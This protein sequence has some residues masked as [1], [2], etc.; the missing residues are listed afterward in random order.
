MSVISDRQLLLVLLASTVIA[1]DWRHPA[2]A[3]TSPAPGTPVLK[4]ADPTH[5]DTAIA[6]R[7]Q[8]DLETDRARVVV[9]QFV[10]W[11]NTGHQ[12]ADRMLFHVA[13]NHR[14]TERQCEI[15]ER[16]IESLRIEPRDSLDRHGR[17][18]HLVS[19]TRRGRKLRHWF[20]PEADTHLHVQLDRFV[21]TGESIEVQLDYWIDLPPL[22]GRVGQFRGVTN[23]LN[24]YPVLAVFGN[25]GWD[26]TPFVGWHQPW[27]NE[28]G[29]YEVTLK[30]PA[31]QRVATG[32]RVLSRIVDERGRQVLQ[33][34]GRSLRDFTIVCSN[35]FESY[36]SEV[37]GI[38]IRVLA[39]LEDQGN[40]RLAL[41][42]AVESIR[43]FSKW[44][45]PYPCREFELVETYFGW[46]GNESSGLVMIDQRIL[47]APRRAGLYV[48]H[49]VTHEI[50]H[51][52]WYSAVGTDG[53]REPFMDE[54][55]VA[56]LTRVA[57]EEKYG[58]DPGVL[59]VPGAGLCGLPNIPYQTLVGSG[60]DLY[61]DRG[62]NGQT[63]STLSEFGHV[64]NL[65]FHVY[66]RGAC[67]VGMIQHRL[68]REWFLAFLSRVYRSYRFRIIHIAD[69]QRELEKFTGQ[70]WQPFFD[71][72][73]R[74]AR[75][76]DW[77]VADVK[78][79]RRRD[80]FHTVVS[81]E[82]QG[83]IFE[84]INIHCVTS[85]DRHDRI[86]RLESPSA[87]Q[88][89]AA[90]RLAM[91]PRNLRHRERFSP[92]DPANGE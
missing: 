55:L 50:C 24:W 81:I 42:I 79:H 3:Q 21:Q 56:W 60:F 73:L 13:P 33:I 47:D 67:I 9:R 41:Q 29:H 86:V 2:V 52:W 35:R 1:T 40:A 23:L 90:S 87:A 37:D 31:D 11:T 26:A 27:H 89:Q 72:W 25:D 32:G 65:F 5:S 78:V 57:I 12:A 75:M 85:R 69:F 36:E 71:D 39:F 17:R 77:A 18:F 43:R 10:Q 53:S 4:N 28:V 91:F 88:G 80:Q 82:Q 84:P 44:F 46:N 7:M 14:P 45:G 16:T 51:Q 20:D 59:D 30:L 22:Q 92:L 15:Y 76:T 54:G 6:Y 64:H 68:G 58:R 8:I 19:L 38:P 49:L 48:E 61:R 83:E 63:Q 70:T 62:G 66:D 34:T 74:S